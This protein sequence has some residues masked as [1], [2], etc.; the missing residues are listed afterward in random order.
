LNNTDT[1][2]PVPPKDQAESHD[3]LIARR[4]AAVHLAHLIR[5]HDNAASLSS[6]DAKFV[7]II[8]DTIVEN[9]DYTPTKTQVYEL[10]QIGAKLQGR[11]E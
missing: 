4:E 5:T 7:E 8:Y 1:S 9:P 6:A 2:W 3:V 10:Q 11:S